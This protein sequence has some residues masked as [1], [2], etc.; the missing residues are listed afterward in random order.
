MHPKEQFCIILNKKYFFKVDFMSSPVDPKVNYNMVYAEG[1]QSNRSCDEVDFSVSDKRIRRKSRSLSPSSSSISTISIEIEPHE[2][3]EIK[4]EANANPLSNSHLKTYKVP[5][6]RPVRIY[7]D[8]IYDLFHYGHARS[9]EQVKK[10]FPDVHLIVGVCND[11]LTHSKKGMTV[12]NDQERA[13]SLRHC[14]W[15]DQVV[16]DAPWVIDQSF[17]DRYAIDF[18]AH[19]DIPYVSDDCSDVYKFVKD[20]DKFI[21]TQKTQGISTSD[22]ITRIVHDYDTY[23][24]RNLE[25]GVSAKALNISIFKL[26][27][28]QMQKSVRELGGKLQSR[29]EVEEQNIRRN[30]ESAKDEVNEALVAW[31]SRSHELVKGF[32]D[33]FQNRRSNF[34][35]QF[36]FWKGEKPVSIVDPSELSRSKSSI[37][38]SSI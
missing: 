28:Y 17:I 9:F 31:E 25:R 33:L 38:S 21:A 5:T 34:F 1:V 23:V 15:V 3:I 22:I 12:F 18:V 4:F 8:G 24:R 20:Q 6:D 35:K 16:E 26:G 13:E 14:K 2:K 7:C 27:E 36:S 19:D 30:W 32:V 10:L 11:A 29:L 37:A